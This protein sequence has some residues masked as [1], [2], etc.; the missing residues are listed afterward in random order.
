VGKEIVNIKLTLAEIYTIFNGAKPGYSHGIPIDRDS[1][2]Q[3]KVSAETTTTNR[4]E[5]R[6]PC[7]S[8]T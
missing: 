1:K 4:Q 3:E 5:T 7:G 2:T 6:V 8:G